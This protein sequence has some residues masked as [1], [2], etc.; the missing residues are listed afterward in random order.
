MQSIDLPSAGTYLLIANFRIRSD[1]TSHGFVKAEVRWN[2]GAA[3]TTE[4][5]MI[6][7]GIRPADYNFTNYGGSVSWIITT[8]KAATA[9]VWYSAYYNNIYKWYNDGNGVPRP[10]AVRILN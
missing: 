9:E 3:H 1:G 8:T 6:C 10:V 5:R 7:E 2:D 4:S